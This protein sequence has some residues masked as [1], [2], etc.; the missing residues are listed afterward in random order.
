MEQGSDWER[1]DD[2][3]LGDADFYQDILSVIEEHEQP[4]ATS[5]ILTALW[6][7]KKYR[8]EFG[9]AEASVETLHH[10]FRT[11]LYEALDRLNND[12]AIAPVE[13]PSEEPI[14]EVAW[15][16]ASSGQNSL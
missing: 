10:R 1:P 4:V 14:P 5:T 16:V 15:R 3:P 6:D 7:G 12:G 13:R 2:L 9:D 11:V 8:R